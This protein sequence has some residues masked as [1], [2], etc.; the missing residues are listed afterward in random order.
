M[1]R[2]LIHNNHKHVG[3][4]IVLTKITILQAKNSGRLEIY[5]N[6]YTNKITCAM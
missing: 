1:C 6:A 2:E 5:T 4:G 3:S